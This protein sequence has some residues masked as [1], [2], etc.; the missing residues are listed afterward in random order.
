MKI[1]MYIMC[2][3]SSN[4]SV[5][6]FALD[7]INDVVVNSVG[8]VGEAHLTCFLHFPA[9][10]PDAVSTPLCQIRTPQHLA[11]PS[12]HR[13]KPTPA[14]PWNSSPLLQI[15]IACRRAATPS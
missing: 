9:W 14:R 11:E 10:Q 12:E 1:G 6:A 5:Q 2:R 15:H 3:K 8:L 7:H 13:C 4:S